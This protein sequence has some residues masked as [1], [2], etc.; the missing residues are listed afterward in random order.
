MPAHSP[1]GD[2]EMGMGRGGTALSKYVRKKLKLQSTLIH[3]VH[4]Q[5][6]YLAP[7]LSSVNISKLTTHDFGIYQ[8]TALLMQQNKKSNSSSMYMIQI[9]AIGKKP[10]RCE[11]QCK[12]CK[13]KQWPYKRGW[14][15]PSTSPPRRRDAMD[16]R[17]GE[18]RGRKEGRKEGRARFS[19]TAYLTML[20]S[21]KHLRKQTATLLWWECHKNARSC[22]YASGGEW[23]LVR[24]G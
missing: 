3:M 6:Q 1:N 14:W 19:V 10:S 18:Q 24:R 21:G 23:A 8:S 11:P 20:A 2:W 4:A 15:Y 16:G 22:G 17:I 12:Y 13:A 9:K 7:M 5:M